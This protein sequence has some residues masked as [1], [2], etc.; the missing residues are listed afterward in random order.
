MLL[1]TWL[2][3]RLAAMLE[4]RDFEDRL[5]VQVFQRANLTI[6]RSREAPL[7]CV[8]DAHQARELDVAPGCPWCAC[9][10]S[11][12]ASPMCRFP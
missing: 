7:A 10:V 1:R 2:T 9:A 4:A 5:F 6:A 8:A 3:S 11:A 12:T